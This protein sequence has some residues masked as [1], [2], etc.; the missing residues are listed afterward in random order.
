M[1]MF[2]FTAFSLTTVQ[3]TSEKKRYHT[4]MNGMCK[5]VLSM[6]FKKQGCL[7]GIIGVSVKLSDQFKL[8]FTLTPITTQ[9]LR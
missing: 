4:F 1:A 3:E 2:F 9:L 8:N 7:N 5:E 6:Q